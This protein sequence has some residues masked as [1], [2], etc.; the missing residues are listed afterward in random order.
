MRARGTEMRQTE[1]P[2][3]SSPPKK[4]WQPWRWFIFYI[5]RTSVSAPS[6]VFVNPC[7][8]TGNLRLN[9][10]TGSNKGAELKD[11][12]NGLS[13]LPDRRWFYFTGKYC[14][15]PK[16]N[17]PRVLSSSPDHIVTARLQTETS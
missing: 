13:L 11:S 12:P 4:E 9:H 17:L 3:T 2:D 15:C 16:L 14:F 5:K 7:A 8:F 10:R 6:C 1:K